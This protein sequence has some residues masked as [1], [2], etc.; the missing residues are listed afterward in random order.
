MIELFFIGTPFCLVYA[1]LS[2]FE[3]EFQKIAM[4]T[5]TTRNVN[6]LMKYLTGEHFKVNIKILLTNVYNQRKY[7][8][9]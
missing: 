8:N 3:F 7:L 9:I 5:S 1:R 2:M 6:F 4:G